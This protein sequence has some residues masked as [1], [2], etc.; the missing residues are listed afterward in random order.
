MSVLVD[1]NIIVDFLRQRASAANFVAALEDRPSVSVVTVSELYA[2]ARTRR[3]E[4]QIEGLL[5]GSNVLPVTLD[6]ART[7]GQY[8]KHYGA[9]H[10]LDDF[11]ALIAA[12]AEHHGLALATL[13]VKHFPMLKGLKAAW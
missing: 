7:A 8:I 2:G 1:T 11:D 5:T 10:G 9:S 4:A 13:N 3:E 6:I 12:T